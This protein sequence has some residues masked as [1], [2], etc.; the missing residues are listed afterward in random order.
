MKGVTIVLK[1]SNGVH[2]GFH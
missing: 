1:I 2:V